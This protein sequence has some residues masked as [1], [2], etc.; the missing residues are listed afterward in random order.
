MT[1]FNVRDGIKLS[2]HVQSGEGD[3]HNRCVQYLTY[4]HLYSVYLR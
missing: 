2:V 1:A 4:V 3:K